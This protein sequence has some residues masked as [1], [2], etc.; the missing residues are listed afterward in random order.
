[1]ID[2]ERAGFGHRGATAAA[3]APR[4]PAAADEIAR[5]IVAESQAQA[6]QDEAEARAWGRRKW[7]LSLA[8]W[9]P[10]SEWLK[11]FGLGLVT[12]ALVAGIRIFARDAAYSTPP[13][14]PLDLAPGTQVALGPWRLP[15]GCPTTSWK[16]ADHLPRACLNGTLLSDQAASAAGLQRPAHYRG[17]WQHWARADHDAL[18]TYCNLLLGCR[19]VRV[20]P[21][22]FSD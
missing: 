18:L 16:Q 20:V 15:A 21:G 1:M 10:S 19:V 4:H 13:P 2:R 11:R 9:A 8:G 12:F 22:K 14:G 6:D 7:T 5:R 3:D 17:G